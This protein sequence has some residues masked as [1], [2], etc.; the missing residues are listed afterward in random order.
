MPLTAS[1]A[2]VRQTERWFVRRGVPQMIARYEF[3]RHVLP[4]MVP[5]LALVAF[6]DI[7]WFGSL[8]AGAGGRSHELIGLAAVVA[9]IAAWPLLT[10]WS[11]R[12]PR[13][14]L[15]TAWTLL[16]GYAVLLAAVPLT[17]LK[18][19]WSVAGFSYYLLVAVSATAGGY[20]VVTYGLLP[21][22]RSAVRHAIDDMRNSLRLQG[23]AL[24]MLLFVT[25]FFFFTGELWQ[26]MQRLGWDR[27]GWVLLL[28]AAVTILAS[29]GRL[30]DE[31]GRVEQDLRP[32]RLSHAC[33]RTPLST[34]D[35]ADVAPDGPLAPVRLT[36]GQVTNLLVI[37]ATRQLVQAAVVGL[38]L[39]GFFVLLGV[40]V[41]TR[42]TAEQ[43][44]GADPVMLGPVPLVLLKNATVIAGFGSMYFAVNS[45]IDGEQ[46]HQF[47]APILDE[48]ERILA[49][50]AVYL[51]V[52]DV[53]LPNAP[54][55]RG[56]PVGSELPTQPA[57]PDQPS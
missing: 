28:F 27:V 13:L 30:R 34:V 22:L 33:K 43:W 14:S 3:R 23:R 49:V 55:A 48:V 5:Y 42:D 47:F 52:R 16:A 36:N 57:A 10:A 11:R 37:L 50:H 24:P 26:A 4:R 19:G 6:V 35:M 45:M 38:G 41:V 31:I 12:I 46:R 51:T 25:L 44:I 2:L 18:A 9:G 15:V 53:V 1:R 56:R 40:L 39:C 7:A 54:A 32:E 29:A 20:L 17:A 21:L 8:A